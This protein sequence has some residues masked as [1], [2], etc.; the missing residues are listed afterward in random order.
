MYQHIDS[1]ANRLGAALGDGWAQG[2]GTAHLDR[3]HLPR[4]DV[5]LD[6]AK[7]IEV[8]GRSVSL[9]VRYQVALVVAISG[10]GSGSEPL[11]LLDRAFTTAVSAL[12]FWQPPAIE[13]LPSSGARL[14]LSDLNDM[15]L[16]GADLLGY[17]LSFDL[18]VVR[19]GATT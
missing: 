9:M 10:A 7:P 15:Q 6:T 17:E 2:V 18:T 11:S 14:Q 16:M 4:F 12:H 1:I 3:R 5:R 8:K 13:G 19:H